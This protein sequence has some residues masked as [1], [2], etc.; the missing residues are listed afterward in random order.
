MQ[1]ICE[2]ALSLGTASNAV[3]D[4]LLCLQFST[5]ISIYKCHDDAKDKDF[6]LEL[7]WI[8]PESGMKHQAVPAH[9]VAVSTKCMEDFRDHGIVLTRSSSFS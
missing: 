4:R 1:P 9:I 3:T 8:C 2:Y 7:S 5:F 6:E